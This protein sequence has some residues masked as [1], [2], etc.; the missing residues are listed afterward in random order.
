MRRCC[1]GDVLLTTPLL[2]AL[3]AAF[4][5]AQITYA[6]GAWSRAALDGNPHVDRVLTLPGPMR[7]GTWLALVRRLRSRRFDLAV[8]PERSP[9]P[10]V[11]AAAARIPRRVGLDSGG[12]GFALTDPV[13]VTG[14]RHETDRALDLANALRLAVPPRHPTYSPSEA[15]REKV[16]ELLDAHAITDPFIVVHPGGG[17]NPGVSMPTKRWPPE[18]FAATAAAL[19]RTYAHQVV[20]TGG[21]ADVNAARACAAAMPLPVLNLA[22]RLTWDE[23]AALAE[24]A[25][26]YL[27]NDSGATHLAVAVG[28]P[29]VVVFG[30]T[31]PAMYGPLDGV[32]EAVWSTECAEAA[33]R[34]DLTRARGSD[35]CIDSI[36]V[37]QVAAAAARVIERSANS[38]RARI[39]R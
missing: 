23:H 2:A 32:S 36:T 20:V 39:A 16:T 13:P 1:F 10:Q 11:L 28:A 30:P 18:R 27:G 33:E 15:S 6:T 4:P 8:I 7:P 14:V 22:K 29:T 12:R 17:D 31:D 35:R 26:L 21:P 3:D 34:G 37:D 38:W 9:L 25:R 19:A 5:A 24:R